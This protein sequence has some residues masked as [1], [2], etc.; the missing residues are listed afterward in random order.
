MGRARDDR[1]LGAATATRS[2][3]TPRNLTESRARMWRYPA[4]TRGRRH[5]DPVQEEIF[6]PLRGTL[7]LLLD[8]PPQRVDVEP[9]GLVAVHPGTPMQ[10]RNEIGRGDS[11]LR[12]RRA[13]RARQRAVPRRRRRALA[14]ASTR[15]TARRARRTRPRSSTCRGR[16][17]RAQ[18]ETARSSTAGTPASAHARSTPK[19]SIASTSQAVPPPTFPTSRS[20][21]RAPPAALPAPRA[22]SAA[23]GSSRS[24]RGRRRHGIE[25]VAVDGLRAEHERRRIDPA[26]PGDPDVEHRVGPPLGERPR[27]LQRRL[28]RPD[29]AAERVD[30]AD[31]RELPLGGGHDE[32]TTRTLPHAACRLAARAARGSRP[33]GI[34]RGVHVDV[35]LVLRERLEHGAGTCRRAAAAAALA[36]AAQRDDD[37]AGLAHRADV[38]VRGRRGARS[39][40]RT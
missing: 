35:E 9:G 26:R 33:F 7:T 2:S 4:H 21:A 3:P 28:D 31:V 36:R 27:R 37:A 13:A 19:P 17:R 22:S 24:T 23:S 29:P 5:I 25:H 16:A 40:S 6:V 8:D 38:D 1:R 34:L 11:L 12:L 30:A 14:H 20:A 10:A 32:H 39:A 18:F 15:A